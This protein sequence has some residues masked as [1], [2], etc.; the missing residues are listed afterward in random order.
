MLVDAQMAAQSCIVVYLIRK[1][2]M[3]FSCNLSRAEIIR[4]FEELIFILS[5]AV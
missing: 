4:D 2:T 3:L 1:V 5:V